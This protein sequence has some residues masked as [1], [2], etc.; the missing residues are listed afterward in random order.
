MAKT[1]GRRVLIIPKETH[2][3][4]TVEAI[5]SFDKSPKI[6]YNSPL[7]KTSEAILEYFRETFDINTA[8]R[9][10]DST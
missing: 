2:K 9:E 1:W 5:K 7:D 6:K 3:Q 8:L 4:L 10:S